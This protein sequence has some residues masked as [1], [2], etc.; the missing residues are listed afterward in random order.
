MHD[1]RRMLGVG[2]PTNP[3]LFLKPPPTNRSPESRQTMPLQ[4]L[5]MIMKLPVLPCVN[6]PVVH[7]G[8]T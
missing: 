5:A 1:D 6:A 4:R 3:Y 2:E 7:P 8:K